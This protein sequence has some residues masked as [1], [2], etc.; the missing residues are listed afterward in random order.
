MD[1]WKKIIWITFTVSA[2]SLPA[3]N[4]FKVIWVHWSA[5]YLIFKVIWSLKF[6]SILIIWCLFFLSGQYCVNNNKRWIHFKN[7]E[8][9]SNNVGKTKV[10]IGKK[11]SKWRSLIF[12]ITSVALICTW[13]YVF[14]YQIMGVYLHQRIRV[15]VNYNF[16]II[17]IIL[18]NITECI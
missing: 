10:F 6:I 2:H 5:L 16:V 7:T 11:Y 17:L 9:S 1:L 4:H 18:L 15:Q 13:I 3:F 8:K 12:P 14:T